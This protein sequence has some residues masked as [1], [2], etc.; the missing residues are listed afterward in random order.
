MF[1]K[2]TKSPRFKYLLAKFLPLVIGWFSAIFR[3][4]NSEII[5]TEN[6]ARDERYSRSCLLMQN[7]F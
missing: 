3:V 5:T 2:V 1:C 7:Q 6:K 4:K